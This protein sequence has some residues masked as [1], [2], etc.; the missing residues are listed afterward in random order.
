MK[1]VMMVLAIAMITAASANAAVCQWGLGNAPMQYG[2][3]N[4]AN[5][6]CQLYLVVDGGYVLLDERSTTTAT[7]TPPVA[8]LLASGYSTAQDIFKHGDDI[9]GTILNNTAQVVMVVYNAAGTHYQMSA[10]ITLTGL[11]AANTGTATPTFN[12]ST[13]W[14]AGAPSL[15]IVP[16]P[17]AMA[18][19]ALGAAAVGLRRR[20]R[21]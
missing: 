7:G 1:K 12:W 20:F 16:E 9:Y 3:A 2:G 14:N 5:A 19:L 21:K 8:G 10:P 4:Q 13:G 18:L 6:V 15:P 11:S 17:T